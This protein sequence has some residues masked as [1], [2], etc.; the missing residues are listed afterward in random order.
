MEPV[1]D[2]SVSVPVGVDALGRLRMVAGHRA[3]ESRFDVVLG[4]IAGELVMRPDVGIEL[5]WER[6]QLPERIA[7]LLA[8]VNPGV[9]IDAVV[10]DDEPRGRPA[11]RPQLGVDVDYQLLE[12]GERG[13]YRGS[14]EWPS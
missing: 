14:I 7:D 4:T 9:R 6:D 13:R 11:L 1:A 5:D 8:R 12:S 2:A 3:V 10:V